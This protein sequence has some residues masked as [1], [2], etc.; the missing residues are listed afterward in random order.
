MEATKITPYSKIET[1]APK[2]RNCYFDNE[3]PLQSQQQYSY[4][5]QWKQIYTNKFHQIM[6]FILSSFLSP[7]LKY[8]DQ[9][10]C[11][12]EC[13][14]NHTLTRMNE[15]EKCLPWFTPPISAEFRICSPFEA[16]NFTDIFDKLSNEICKVC[17]YIYFYSNCN[18]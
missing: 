12:L 6:Y 1:I 9:A 18:N 15:N 14:I 10:S 16:T 3:Y 11:V 13:R 8:L 4:V 2:E 5:R 7:S 17:T